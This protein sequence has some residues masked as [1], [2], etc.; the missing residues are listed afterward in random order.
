MGTFRS[1][2]LACF[3]MFIFLGPAL[4]GVAEENASTDPW[5]P[6]RFLAGE[7]N[8]SIDGR[9]GTGT[10]KRHYGFVLGGRFLVMKH[11]SV[12]LPQEKSPQG[13]NHEEIG[14]FSVD[15]ERNKL[16]L[17][18]FNIEG[19]ILQYA[20][21]AVETGRLVC[22]TEQIENGRGIRARLT[23]TKQSSHSFEEV[24]EIAWREGEDLSVYFTNT[25]TR[26]PHLG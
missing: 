5:K 19:F 9:L 3:T 14:I 20:C 16:V 11:S 2:T 7:W 6:L 22:V 4:F 25:W 23:V 12:R 24:F 18:S 21:D 10:G 1:F 17:R 15:G 26:A 13:D 8:G